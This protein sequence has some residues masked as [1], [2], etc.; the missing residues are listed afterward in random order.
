MK[1]YRIGVFSSILFIC[2]I[3][4]VSSNGEWDNTD[5]VPILECKINHG[6]G[7]CQTFWGYDNHNDQV[8]IITIG[9]NNKFIPSPQNRGQPFRFL[10]GVNRYAFSTNRNCDDETYLTWSVC[11]SGCKTATCDTNTNCQKGCDGVWLSGKT[12]D[13]CGVCGGN[14]TCDTNRISSSTTVFTTGKMTVINTTGRMTTGIEQ[15][16]GQA[17]TSK[18]IVTTGK[19]S[20]MQTTGIA[21]TGSL[22]TG[23]QTTGRA[24]TG[25]ATTGQATTGQATTGQITTG[26]ATTGQAT[27]GSSVQDPCTNV[28]L[29]S[30]IILINIILV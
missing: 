22:S 6:N 1:R 24:T 7:T 12:Y 13:H 27:T 28:S 8:K 25:R 11:F 3:G 10:P 21:S 23:Q 5:I 19:I 15:T 4:L 26:Q 17:T 16:T 9:D 20:V 18:P 2:S 29:L 14:G 30:C